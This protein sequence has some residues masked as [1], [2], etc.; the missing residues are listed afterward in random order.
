M[1][2][3]GMKRMCVAIPGRVVE[4][5]EQTAT[6]DFNG[7]RVRALTGMVQVKMNDY[8]LVHAGCIIQVLWTTQAEELMDLMKELECQE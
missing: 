7:N 6:V 2:I 5:Q 4:I 3:E 1:H 8:V